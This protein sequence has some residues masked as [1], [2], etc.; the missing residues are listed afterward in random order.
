MR[1]CEFGV[2]CSLE[3]GAEVEEVEERMD[4]SHLLTR[5]ND[6]VDESN[7]NQPRRQHEHHSLA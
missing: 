5:Q 6:M 2:D 1:N 7:R 4:D 3:R